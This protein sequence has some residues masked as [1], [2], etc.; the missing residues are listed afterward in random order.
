MVVDGYCLVMVVPTLQRSKKPESERTP[1]KERSTL[2]SVLG[3]FV[4]LGVA[5]GIL[6][7]L[8]LSLSARGHGV[9]GDAADGARV[10]V[11]GVESTLDTN[12]IDRSDIPWKADE[13]AHLVGWG[14]ITVVAGLLLR[15]RRSISDIAVGVFAASFAVEILQQ[16]ATTSRTMQAEDV[17]ANALGV[18]LGLMVLVAAERL[19]RPVPEPEV[20]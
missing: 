14:M 6:A 9:V 8:W 15:A 13:V 4:V 7:V 5:L 18:M 1:E 2:R 3:A 16:V 17:S 20:T 10:V 19:I 11:R 12:I